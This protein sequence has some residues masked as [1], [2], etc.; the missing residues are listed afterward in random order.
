MTN[1]NEIV[2]IHSRNGG[3]ASV[4]ETNMPYQAYDNGILKG[5][6]V[7]ASTE[8]NI[9]VGGSQNKPDVVIG[10]NPAGYRI[11]LDIIGTATFTLVPPETNSR[12]TAVVAYTDDLAAAST[13]TTVTGNPSSC[14]LLL[15]NG[16]AS[17][18]PVAPDDTTIRTAITADGAT[19]S[20]ATYCVLAYITLASNTTDITDTLI[21][22][23]NAFFIRLVPES[24]IDSLEGTAL[25]ANHF[26]FGYEE[27]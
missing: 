6:G 1:P 21:E 22:N 13:D 20:Q 19:G 24:Q 3:R 27:S 2:R 25:E 11:A 16:A 7:V 8:L 5:T 17:A 15:V 10:L 4:Y 12:I 14:G 9:N 18:N 26:I 23:Q